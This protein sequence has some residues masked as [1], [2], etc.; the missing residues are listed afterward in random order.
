[1]KRWPWIL[2]IGLD[3]IV[4][5]YALKTLELLWRQHVRNQLAARVARVVAGNLR[6]NR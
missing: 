2:L 4:P 1:M 6:K 3:V 5:Q